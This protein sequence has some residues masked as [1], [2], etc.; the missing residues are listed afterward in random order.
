MKLNATRFKKEKRAKKNNP[1][2]P[3][4]SEKR[5]C[6]PPPRSGNVHQ[7]SVAHA[8]CMRTCSVSA[9]C[10]APPAMVYHE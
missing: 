4:N 8:C 3:G 6:E 7:A 9:H 10:A 5:A 1:V 2:R